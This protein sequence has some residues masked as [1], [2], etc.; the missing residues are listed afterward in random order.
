VRIVMVVWLIGGPLLYGSAP[1]VRC[2]EVL[3]AGETPIVWQ[4]V[5]QLP[6]WALPLAGISEGQDRDWLEANSDDTSAVSN[7]IQ[8]IAQSSSQKANPSGPAQFDFSA[9]FRDLASGHFRTEVS[10]VLA[11]NP[12]ATM[13]RTS[14]LVSGT[15][16]PILLWSGLVRTENERNA[17][18]GI[19]VSATL[20]TGTWGWAI[21]Q[22]G[23]DYWRPPNAEVKAISTAV[24]A[25]RS[26]R[27][28]YLTGKPETGTFGYSD[29]GQWLLAR[30]EIDVVENKRTARLQ[31]LWIKLA[32]D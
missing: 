20:F 11:D 6:K 8:D 4:P 18:G 22:A 29:D 31:L 28:A 16:L 14:S 19:I 17:V 5:S 3:A 7:F 23:K 27:N 25:A 10:L 15:L 2:T 12:M 30:V 13:V 1:V 21:V 9:L 24:S 32:Q 26:L